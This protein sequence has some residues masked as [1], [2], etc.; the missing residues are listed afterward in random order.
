MKHYHFENCWPTGFPFH[1]VPT[2]LNYLAGIVSYPNREHEYYE[3]EV[4]P[5]SV[6]LRFI[7]EN[8]CGLDLDW[9]FG[10]G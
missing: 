7:D 8:R 9:R 4:D 2:N 10:S 6:V 3:L 5:C 1:D